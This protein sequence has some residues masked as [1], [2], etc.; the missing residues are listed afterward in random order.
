[1]RDTLLMPAI[2]KVFTFN[3]FSTYHVLKMLKGVPKEERL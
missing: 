2:F 1:M 3:F